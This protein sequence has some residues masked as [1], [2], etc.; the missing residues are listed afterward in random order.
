M[1]RKF[2]ETPTNEFLFIGQAQRGR[3]LPAETAAKRH[4]RWA[5][6]IFAL[7]L[8][9]GITDGKYGDAHGR[10]YCVSTASRLASSIKRIASINKPVVFFVVVVRVDSLA[11]LK[12][13]SNSPSVHK[14]TL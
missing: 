5:G 14:I 12:S 4:Y 1:V 13:I 8:R 9:H 7:P 10:D 6:K 2:L 3:N 11:A